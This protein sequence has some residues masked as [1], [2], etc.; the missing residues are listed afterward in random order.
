[1]KREFDHRGRK[2]KGG[3]E[4]EE[5]RRDTREPLAEG[6]WVQCVFPE[7]SDKGLISQDLPYRESRKTKKGVRG[8]A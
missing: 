6:V 8:V 2:K 7:I 3:I 5:R 1:M 4:D